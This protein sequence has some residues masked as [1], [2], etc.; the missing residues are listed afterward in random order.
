MDPFSVESFVEKPS[1]RV[2]RVLK[3]SQLTTLAQ[4]FKLELTTTMK[5][6]E[7][8]QLVIDYL[9]DEELV[10]DEELEATSDHVVS[11]N[12]VELKRLELAD[13]EKERESQLKLKEL[14][15]REKELNVQLRLKELEAPSRPSVTPRTVESPQFDISKQI[16]FV[17][18]FQEKEVDKYF[19]H[20]E[21][22]ATSLDWPKDVWT[23]LLQSV[24]T[25]KAREIYSALSVEQSSRYDTVKSAIMKAYELVPEAYRQQFRGSQRQ[26][27]QTFTE[28]AREKEAQFDR[29]CTA[30]EVAQDFE[31]LRQLILLE[32]FK[33]C[34]PPQVKTYLDER[35][36][37]N[38]SQAA[39]LVDDYSLTHKSTFVKEEK[40][41]VGLKGS[42]SN[43]L[44]P[45]TTGHG[46]GKNS[47]LTSDPHPPGGRH[48]PSVPT[49]YY[50]R[51]KGHIMSECWE[52]AKKKTKPVALVTV[53][54]K[55]SR[56]MLR[57][58]ESTKP[59]ISKGFISVSKGEKPVPICILRDT[60][61]TQSLLVDHVLP[62][63]D[64][65]ATGSQVLIQGV[66]LGVIPVP[67]HKVYLSSDLVSGTVT[68]GVR[69]TL[70]FEGVSFILGNDLAGE[71][72]VSN[73][74]VVNNVNSTN[75][76]DENGPE[77]YPAC[78]IT[79]A[80]A[81]HADPPVNLGETFL[82]QDSP[83]L[84]NR[85][86]LDVTGKNNDPTHPGVGRET[87][88]MEQENDPELLGLA[89]EAMTEE[90]MNVTPEGY[91]KQSGVLMR[92]W[93]PRDTP[94]SD[95]WRTVYQ[96]VVPKTKRSEVLSVAHESALAGHLGVNKTYQKV[97][98]H[99]FW[100][101]LRKDV[102]NYC[103]TCHVC[104]MA[105]K[106]NQ[107]IPKAPLIPIPAFEEPF[108][109]VI[110]DCVGPLPKTKSGNQYLLTLMCA[111]TR[112]PE[113]VPLRNIKAPT[114][115]KH[116]VKFFTLVGLPKSLQS[117]QGSNFMSGLM[118]QV[119]T[120]L[121][122]KQ[123]RSSAYHPESQG[124]LERFHQT[125]KNMLRAYGLEHG[126][127]WDEGV[128]LVLFAAREAVEESLG[129]SP[130]EL[131]F[132][133]AVR[134]PLKVLK[135]AWL[136]E[137]SSVNLLEYVSRLRQR[138]LDAVDIARKNLKNSQ[139]RMKTW[140]DK[141]AKRRQFHVGEKVLALLPIPSQPLQARYY[142]PYEV[143]KKVDEVNYIL[144][145]PG[146]RKTQRLCHV[147]MLKQYHQRPE[148]TTSG[149][150]E[151]AAVVGCIAERVRNEQLVGK[152]DVLAGSPKLK[153][154]D[155]LKELQG[156]KL[157]H[158]T[159]L[160]QT[161]MMHLIFEFV[162]LFPD[163]P[164]RTN[165]TIHDV[166]V[167]ETRP[168]KQHPYRLNPLKL[169]VMRQEI[170]YMLQNDLIEASSSGWS[171]PC[172]LV[173]KPDGTYRFC[174]DFRQVNKATK[175]DSYPIP[176]VDDCVDKV[177]NA[178]YVTKLDL[179]KGYWQVPLSSRA[180]EISAFTT[181][182]GLFQYKVMPFGMKNA[183]ATFQ[184]LINQDWR[185]VVRI[186]MTW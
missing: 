184:R 162:K 25:G 43:V 98:S 107:Q 110:I 54:K 73:L 46:S 88:I 150:K 131:V 48:R 117:D 136:G 96:V 70:P 91:F 68:V 34:L 169:K 102:V 3:K 108:S 99:F 164:T 106:P 104:Q 41:P 83:S 71:K 50:C 92:K 147:N 109:R 146:R 49:C 166:D 180:K 123:Y 125:L 137:D 9:V 14:E 37:E 114:I 11:E 130:F 59:F 152:E 142:G 159:P 148:E 143:I 133:R 119:M 160:E 122:I 67:L 24:L 30:K 51:R 179:L 44:L 155:I 61:A 173:P 1:L 177:G 153:N 176:R 45:A 127:D 26:I 157:S 23:L 39:V 161:E 120:Q 6:S 60:G 112:F 171:S 121:G 63:S 100:P 168:I 135:E 5:K 32:E 145:T 185:V 165:R 20:F 118:Q 10:S 175:S 129:F 138:I 69:P 62:L 74:H 126:R 140:Y 28:F 18:P 124:A 36:V 58:G 21:K 77:V 101:G 132:G 78:A 134:G 33:G 19:L 40:D 35:K 93:R 141:K 8:K 178:K 139:S 52:Y 4:H 158:L 57:S 53:P 116:L 42:H 82:V 167:G 97:L 90:E 94:S 64:K 80:M 156:I 31:K 115:V 13:K 86:E 186:L 103:R 16:R 105:G 55:E 172:V 75:S 182:D 85:I 66:E 29:W 17:P 84:A 7:V 65:T 163:T 38:L 113:A 149:G 12:A 170:D 47:R 95:H 27:S 144:N 15:I 76:E 89:A 111:S 154:S 22:I 128:H 81:K 79:R 2:V 174:T 181:P 183:P 72:V 56:G 151:A 87:L